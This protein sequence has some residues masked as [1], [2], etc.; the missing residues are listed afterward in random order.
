MSFIILADIHVSGGCWNADAW[1]FGFDLSED[2]EKPKIRKG[3]SDRPP[4]Q[5]PRQARETPTARD[6][7]GT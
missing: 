6:E 4:R 5:I 2:K 3:G 1:V 7:L